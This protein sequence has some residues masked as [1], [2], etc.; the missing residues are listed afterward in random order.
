MCSKDVRR[1]SGRH[2]KAE[3]VHCPEEQSIN[4]IAAWLF[5]SLMLSSDSSVENVLFSSVAHVLIRLF[6]LLV[7]AGSSGDNC[8]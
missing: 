5:G 8:I 3:S 7:V 4:G 6:G 2:R 1:P